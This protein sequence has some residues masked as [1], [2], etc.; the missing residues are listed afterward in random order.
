MSILIVL[1]ASLLILLTSVGRDCKFIFKISFFFLVIFKFLN[2][3]QCFKSL[4]FNI[5]KLYFV[6]YF[7]R[8]EGRAVSILGNKAERKTN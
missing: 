3:S 1:F 8:G 5:L 6:M 4:N 7:N 2:Y